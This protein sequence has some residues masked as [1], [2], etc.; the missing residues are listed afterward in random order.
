MENDIR[1]FEFY[2][3][4]F[5]FSVKNEMN[6]PAGK[7]SQLHKSLK[8]RTIIPLT[9]KICTWTKKYLGI[10]DVEKKT[11]FIAVYME[12]VDLRIQV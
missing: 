7:F 8:N 5:F 6:S 1:S 4:N 9:L 11:K 10:W 2:R 3:S 12:V